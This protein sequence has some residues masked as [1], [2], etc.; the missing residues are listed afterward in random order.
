VA[1][2]WE[3]LLLLGAPIGIDQTLRH[4]YI[5]WGFGF[6]LLSTVQAF[7][8]V[9]QREAALKVELAERGRVPQ[10]DIVFRSTERPYIQEVRGEQEGLVFFER[11]F[12]VGI[13]SDAFVKDVHVLLESCEPMSDFV[14]PAHA[15]AVMGRP[16]GAEYFDVNPGADPAVFVDVFTQ[17]FDERSGVPVDEMN[18]FHLCYAQQALPSLFPT[19]RHRLA[20]RA[21]GSGSFVRRHFAI[22]LD[23][24][25]DATLRPD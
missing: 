20:I 7:W 23:A 19:R 6:V 21:E 17:R 3:G 13:L 12:R 10:L 16:Q 14:F 4:E 1:A 11:R 22:E 5:L 9:L 24:R 18:L 15:L 8:A 2:L 25:G